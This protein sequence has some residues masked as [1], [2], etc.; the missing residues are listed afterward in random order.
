MVPPRAPSFAGAIHSP[1]QTSRRAKP[2]S[3]GDPQCHHEREDRLAASDLHVEP[4]R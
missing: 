3:G 1:Q 2:G 4:L